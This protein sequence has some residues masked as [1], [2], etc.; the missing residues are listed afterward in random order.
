MIVSNTAV[1]DLNTV[2]AAGIPVFVVAYFAAHS[3]PD[4]VADLDEPP[5]L[6]VPEPWSEEVATLSRRRRRTHVDTRAHH[7]DGTRLPDPLRPEPDHD[8]PD[9]PDGLVVRDRIRRRC[10]ARYLTAASVVLFALLVS[11][12]MI[13]ATQV[14]MLR[15]QLSEAGKDSTDPFHGIVKAWLAACATTVAAVLLAVLVVL[16]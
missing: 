16:P 1:S 12:I 11:S 9:G 8:R 3:V 14:T 5:V 10:G 6:Q 2:R 4:N 13:S 15:L 7:R